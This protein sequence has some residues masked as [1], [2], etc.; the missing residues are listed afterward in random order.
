MWQNAIM[1]LTHFLLLHSLPLSTIKHRGMSPNP[2]VIG[3]NQTRMASSY[4]TPNSTKFVDYHYPCCGF[5]KVHAWGNEHPIC[6]EIVRPYRQHQLQLSTELCMQYQKWFDN[7][8]QYFRH[9]DYMHYGIC[10]IICS[11]CQTVYL[12]EALLGFHITECHRGPQYFKDVLNTCYP[13]V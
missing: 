12:S 4:D 11:L 8:I 5:F 9:Q 3:T 6:S 10:A 2:V 7:A 13:C 1:Q